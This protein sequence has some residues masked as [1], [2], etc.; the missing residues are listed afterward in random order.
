MTKTQAAD[1]LRRLVAIWPRERTADTDR[2][3]MMLM[4]TLDFRT[5]DRALDELRDTL[6]FTPSVADFR[7]AYRRAAARPDDYT[8][9]PAGAH[10]GD[11]T[12]LTDTYGSCEW[13]Y[14]WRCDMALT[15]EERATDA[16]Y[17]PVRGL[18]HRRCPRGGAAPIIPAG[19]RI[20][21]QEYFEKVKVRIGPDVDP[22]VYR[23]RG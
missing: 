6:G 8:A 11:D 2:E 18:Y 21:R 14:C 9:L 15:L 13:V 3:W 1:V 17:D 10:S 16:P 7:A 23:G 20:A 12:T 4:R 22:A 5:A 19:E